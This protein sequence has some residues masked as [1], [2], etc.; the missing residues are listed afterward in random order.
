MKLSVL[1]NDDVHMRINNNELN[2]NT[3][4]ICFY[5]KALG[6]PKELMKSGARVLL[7]PYDD[8]DFDDLAC[9]DDYDFYFPK[10]RKTAEFIRSAVADGCELICL[11]DCGSTATLGCAAAIL[12]YY[13]GRGLDIFANE[14]YI[15]NK[16]V[17]RKVYDAL[18][19]V[20]GQKTQPE[21]TIEI[22]ITSRS[23][24]QKLIHSGK[25]GEDTAVISFCDVGTKLL[26]FANTQASVFTLA[27]DDLG[28]EEISERYGSVQRYFTKADKLVDFIIR[29]VASGKKFICQCEMGMSRSAACAA[30][31]L[32]YYCGSGIS[33][34]ADRRYY[35]NRIIFQK[36]FSELCTA[37]VQEET[38]GFEF[39]RCKDKIMQSLLTRQ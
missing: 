13:E 29:S 36:L 34:F 22:A 23:K 4:V 17:Y 33:I 3:A 27:L 35:P 5:S 30:A 32:Q 14:S 26:Y 38:S 7:V 1:S 31:I 24:M 6:K 11:D 12:E 2:D 19:E 16:L 10:A 21:N 25:L 37:G 15:P 39:Y 20:C 9:D 8:E 18:C 28:I